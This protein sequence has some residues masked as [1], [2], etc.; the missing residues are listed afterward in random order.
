[1]AA[2]HHAVASGQLAAVQM[3][4]EH[5]ASIEADDR[6]GE[7]AL[8]RCMASSLIS[9]EILRA[10]VAKPVNLETTDSEGKR[11]LHRA[12]L[13][14]SYNAGSVVLYLLENGSKWERPTV[15]AEQHHS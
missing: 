6:T 4:L 14:A 7:T 10:L 9:T 5:G 1:M 2:L 11:V 12:A 8:C 13:S 15:T 3:L